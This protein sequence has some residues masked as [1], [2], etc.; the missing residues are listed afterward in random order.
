MVEINPVQDNNY[1][2]KRSDNQIKG[3]KL[4]NRHSCYDLR[5][6]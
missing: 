4:H 1:K 2:D 3:Q 6:F 5:I